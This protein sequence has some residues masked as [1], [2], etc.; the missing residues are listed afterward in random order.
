MPNSCSNLGWNKCLC[1][2]EEDGGKEC[3]DLG[4]CVESDLGVRGYRIEIKPLMVLEIK[5]RVIEIK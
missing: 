1:I 5:N 2:C 3:D 4:K